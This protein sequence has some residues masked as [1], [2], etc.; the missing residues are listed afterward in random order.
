MD[1][2]RH[3][4][5]RASIIS[6]QDWITVIFSQMDR[7]SFDISSFKPYKRSLN[8]TVELS[9][10]VMMLFSV[11]KLLD[12]MV[13]EVR[14]HLISEIPE[15]SEMQEEDSAFRFIKN[16]VREGFIEQTISLFQSN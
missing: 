14:L 13:E 15:Y 4:K 16:K 9:D 11:E 2:Y 7:N 1:S 12:L 3:D 10:L 6:N 8:A 5:G